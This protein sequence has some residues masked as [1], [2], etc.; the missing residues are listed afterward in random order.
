MLRDVAI[1]GIYTTRQ[2]RDLPGLRTFDLVIEAVRGAIADAGLT[3]SDIDG[4]AVQWPIR[5]GSTLDVSSNWAPWLNKRLRWTND[6]LLDIAGV[7]G[8]LKAAS[9][10]SAGLC[11]TV[12]IG[13]GLGGRVELKHP[14]GEEGAAVGSMLDLEFSTPFG[15]WVMPHFALVAQRHMHEYGTT[16]EQLAQVAATIRNNGHIN[17]EAVMFGRGPYTV[18]DVLASRMVASPL[19]LLDCCLVAQGGFAMVLTSAE[20]ARSLPHPPVLVGGGG[21]EFLRGAYAGPARLDE[22][23][24]LG[25]QACEQALQMAGTELGDVDVFSLYDATSFE[26]IRQVEMLGLCGVGEGGPFVDS[27]AIARDGAFPVNPDGGL[28]SHSWATPGH[29]SQRVIEGVRQL[30]GSAVNQVDDA[31]VALVSNAGSG[32]HHIEVAVLVTA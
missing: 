15:Q 1:V 26:V 25:S 2:A 6:D 27:G 5:S 12:V 13:S 32:T 16:P 21:M 9:A 10:I 18:D 4:A 8:V 11:E 17:P 20:R 3:P 30:R 31:E 7:R 19:H 28:L 29:L 23:E 22:L 24:T 14:P